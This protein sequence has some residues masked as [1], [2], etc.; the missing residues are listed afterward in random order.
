MTMKREIAS[1][2]HQLEALGERERE[3]NGEI[4]AMEKDLEKEKGKRMKKKEKE[5]EKKEKEL[6]GAVEEMT[7]QHAKESRVLGALERETKRLREALQQREKQGVTCVLSEDT[8][9]WLHWT[10]EKE[11]LESSQMAA[12]KAAQR[13]ASRLC[14]EMKQKALESASLITALEARQNN[15]VLKRLKEEEDEAT[16][17]QTALAT[18]ETDLQRCEQARRT[19]ETERLDALKVAVEKINRQ[20]SVLF[21]EITFSVAAG[22]GVTA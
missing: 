7:L 13:K 10:E 2:E 12:V 11:M 3:L 15:T 16:T 21:A 8:K 22:L 19:A 9:H 14:A 17:L 5:L 20:M 1:L 18:I 6:D 4:E